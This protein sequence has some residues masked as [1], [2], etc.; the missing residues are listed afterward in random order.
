MRY[1]VTGGAGFIGSHI[2]DHLIGQ[3]KQVLVVDDFSTGDPENLAIHKA[4]KDLEVIEGN[5]LDSALIKRATR[6]VDRVFHFAA[7]VGVFNIM[8]DTVKSLKTNLQGTENVLEACLEYK[9]PVLIASSSEVYGKNSSDSLSED[10]DRIIGP[11]Q[12]IRWSYSDAKA[13]DE[14]L[15]ISLHRELGLEARILR[16]FNT[17]GPRQVGRYGMVVPRFV[18]AALKGEDLTIYGSG[19][20]TRCFGHV[21]D[22]VDAI[23]KI[24]NTPEAIACPV[25]IGVSEEISILNLA[26]SV[27]RLLNS[28]STVKFVPYE[29]VYSFGFE[30]MQR[31]VPDNAL[32]KK[33]T[34]W[35][36]K[37]GIEEIVL[38]IANHI[39]K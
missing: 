27:L 32:L 33:L 7:A 6:E 31:R 29:E 18:E 3:G 19:E 17:V 37:R 35:Q 23:L 5:I 38:D 39:N 20:Q 8:S 22:I 1:L 28:K 36:P 21:L 11:P 10:S 2:V 34:G 4:S 25:N 9:K 13:I 24:E 12:K 26:S 14:S 16:L 15:A 30:D